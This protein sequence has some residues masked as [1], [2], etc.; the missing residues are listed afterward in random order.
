MI[1]S[2]HVEAHTIPNPSLG[3]AHAKPITHPE[4]FYN[5]K[6]TN[7]G[8]R[9]RVQTALVLEGGGYRG[10]FTAGVLDVLMEHGIYD[11]N[12]VWGVSAGSLGATSFCSHQIGRTI[13]IM[14]AFRDDRRLMSFF[15]L[16][17]TG[18]LTGG[19]FLY[20]T[21]QEQL[22]PCDIQTFNANPTRM[23]AVASDVVFGTPRYFEIRTLPDDVE[24]IRASS[25]LPLVS[26]A[27]EIDG[28]HY[29][30]GGTT[31]S[32]PVE[33]ALGLRHAEEIGDYVPAE[34]AVV[35]LTRQ[36]G[37]Q[38]GNRLER[39]ALLSRRYAAYPLYLEA[40]RARAQRYMEQRE[41]IWQLEREGKLLVIA[42]PKPVEVSANEHSGEPLLDL[43]IQGRE[44]AQG[45]LEELK[46]FVRPKNDACTITS[47][48][49]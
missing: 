24:K 8:R 28:H 1:M 18:N 44:Q 10:V 33:M 23:F 27:V 25:S 22:D 29:L 36:R 20:H 35:I 17:T 30:D 14:L 32:V 9:Q 39:M 41:R 43:Y 11:F 19:E 13:R 2:A 7:N 42:P 38:K 12:S 45:H 47:S 15:S 16:A 48:L 3:P 46:A 4:P 5:G 21:V 34:R 6:T 31:D 49:L 37:Y 26:T 40:L